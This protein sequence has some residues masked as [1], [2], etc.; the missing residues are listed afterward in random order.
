ML[1]FAFNR[2]TVGGVKGRVAESI[3]RRRREGGRDGSGVKGVG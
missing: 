1:N 2:Q 3:G